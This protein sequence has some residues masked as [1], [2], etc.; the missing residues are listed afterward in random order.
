MVLGHHS[1]CLKG[2][3]YKA[4]ITKRRFISF[5]L[6]SSGYIIASDFKLLALSPL[7]CLLVNCRE[8]EGSPDRKKNVGDKNPVRW[9]ACDCVSG[10]VGGISINGVDVL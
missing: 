8:V 9:S 10:K 3:H 7:R 2:V 4:L 1:T 6:S 5:H